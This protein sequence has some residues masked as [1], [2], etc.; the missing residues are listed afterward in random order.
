LNLAVGLGFAPFDP[1]A[2]AAVE[3]EHPR[4]ILLR[5]PASSPG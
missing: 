5:P 4:R 1:A 2:S 3:A